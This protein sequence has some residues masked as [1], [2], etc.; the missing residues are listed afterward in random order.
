MGI[1][2]LQFEKHQI[3]GNLNLD[4]RKPDGTEYQ[5]IIF[6]GENGCGKTTILKEI[7]SKFKKKQSDPLNEE[8]CAFFVPQDLKYQEVSDRI[9]KKSPLLNNNAYE[10]DTDVHKQYVSKANECFSNLHISQYLKSD[11]A[12]NDIAA[13]E[14]G[15]KQSPFIDESLIPFSSLS[16]GEQ[17]IVLRL[18]YISGN[19]RWAT[20]VVAIDEI[21]TALHPRWKLNVLSILKYALSDSQLFVA[22]H[23]ENI[24][25]SAIEQGDW[26]IIRLYR[27]DNEVIQGQKIEAS[28][29]VLPIVTFSEVQ[30][31]VFGIPSVEYHIQLYGHLHNFLKAQKLRCDSISSVDEHI[32]NN[33]N[34]RSDML[35]VSKN[36]PQSNCINGKK[37]HLDKTLPVYIR[38]YIDHPDDAGRS[39]ECL[40]YLKGSI[41]FM[42]GIINS[43]QPQTPPP[44]SPTSSP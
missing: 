28:N 30:F 37:I 43:L 36:L 10:S 8:F 32:N 3:L 38:N 31:L 15:R 29:M 14:I 2:N 22:S 13:T 26:L 44:P 24:L 17:E 12:I 40:K 18:L 25:K 20:D 6:V 27:D 11:I 1:P 39:K 21:E 41:E 16:S 5:H 33:I 4:F 9:I 7:V 19:K 42:I 34:G 23:S 35:V